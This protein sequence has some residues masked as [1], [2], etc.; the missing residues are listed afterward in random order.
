MGRYDKYS[1]ATPPAPVAES[2]IKRDLTA[3]VVIIGS[4]ISGIASA[5][6]CAEH[7]LDVIVIEK[8]PVSVGHGHHF[9][10]SNCRFMRERGYVNNIYDLKREFLRA[11]SYRVNEDVLMSYLAHSEP[12]MD[13]L[14]DK[15]DARGISYTMNAACYK[16][17]AYTE[18][19]GTIMFSCGAD[20]VVKML[21]DEAQKLGVKV[22]YDTPAEQL[23]KEDGRVTGVIA[24]NAE[25]YIRLRGTKGVV[26]ATGDISGNEEMTR[27]L[28]PQAFNAVN[29]RY[30]PV[31]MNTGDGHRMGV[32]AGGIMQETPFPC[33]LHTTAFSTNVFFYLA[34][35]QK[36]KR[37]MNEDAGPQNKSCYTWN[38]DP[39]HPWGFAIFDSKWPGEVRDSLAYGGGLMWDCLE[40]DID[41]PFDTEW[42]RV[43]LEKNIADGKVAWRADTLEELADKIGVPRDVFLATVARYNEIV[44][45]GVDTDYGKRH[46]LLTP[47]NKPPYYATK[48]GASLLVITAGLEIDQLLRVLNEDRE[49]I[50]GLYAVGQAS[51]SIYA[52]DYPL[53][54]PGNDLGRCVTWGYLIGGI[55]AGEKA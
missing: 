4:G 43:P 46:E 51:G 42:V 20:G 30:T 16:G 45:S 14:C 12:A 41:H 55:L 13:W 27:D 2:E 28:A 17:N 53:T 23:I 7:G 38:Q 47:I 21:C 9:G 1:W 31:G 19:P 29:A 22:I 37:Y 34:V 54:I 10:V 36:G 39:K 26:L 15:A 50:P 44:H 25:G 52:V 3:D 35:N 32:W 24:K 48:F 33:I 11:T 8:G 49:P 5:V 6:S 40:H 18:F